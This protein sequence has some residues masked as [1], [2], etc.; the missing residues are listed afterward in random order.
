MAECGL[1]L[2]SV[3]PSCPPGT[4]NS[5]RSGSDCRGVSLS[6]Q[7]TPLQTSLSPLV[8]ARL[9]R[10]TAAEQRGVHS[11]TL[12]LV[13]PHGKRFFV[14]KSGFITAASRS[15]RQGTKVQYVYVGMILEHPLAAALV[16]AVSLQ[17]PG[18]WT[19]CSLGRRSASLGRF[20]PCSSAYGSL[21]AGC[22]SVGMG[23]A[24]MGV[25]R[26][27]QRKRSLVHVQRGKWPSWYRHQ[28][29]TRLVEHASVA[30]TTGS[31]GGRTRL[32]QTTWTRQ[33]PMAVRGIPE[34]DT[35][36]KPR[37]HEQRAA[38]CPDTRGVQEWPITRTRWGVQRRA[39]S[40]ERRAS[41]VQR[42]AFSPQHASS[43]LA[44]RGNCSRQA[45]PR[46]QRRP[47]AQIS[48]PSKLSSVWWIAR[49]TPAFA[50]PA[51]G[52]A[53]QSR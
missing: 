24:F 41:S 40:V 46:L 13:S 36:Q 16:Y 37:L 53:R 31:S 52:C 23:G 25:V 4:F 18:S 9:R 34:A 19:N 12:A 27:S 11:A 20:T 28:C 50:S 22:L 7:R 14:T 51:P 29:Q 10:E 3:P 44:Q 43:R 39:F 6:R 32:I 33:G 5:S 35:A 17:Q 1:V 30:A 42:S 49:L 8:S 45:K 21:Q 26:R 2:D 48:L 38:V 15:L 47:W